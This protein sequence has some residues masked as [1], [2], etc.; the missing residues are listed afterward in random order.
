VRPIFLRTGV[1]SQAKGSS[2]I[3]MDKTKIICAVYGPR[4]VI[5]REEFSLAG[6]LY[7][8]V[9]FATFSCPIRRQHQQDTEEKDFSAILQQA[10]EPAILLEKFPK[11]RMDVYVTV[12][13]D[14][15]SA[16]AGAISAASVALA[17]AAVDMYDLVVGCAVRQ[18]N[19]KTLIDPS[20]SEEYKLKSQGSGDNGSIT[21]GLMPSLHQVAALTQK[22]HMESDVAMQGMKQCIEGCQKLYP[23]LQQCLTKA[24]K[25]RSQHKRDDPANMK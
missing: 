8:E 3:E 17:D 18:C 22:G 24:I 19:Q 23:V 7:C 11:A 20:S 6:Q 13:Q 2:Y 15:G 14:D 25:T 4:E 12:L 9:K 16:L 1:V 10:L 21:V 5:K